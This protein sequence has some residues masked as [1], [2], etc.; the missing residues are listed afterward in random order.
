M[1][2]ILGVL[3]L[4][5]VIGIGAPKVHAITLDDL[6]KEISSLKSQIV[7]LKTQLSA[8]ALNAT[9]VGT[10]TQPKTT[11]TPASCE[12]KNAA[13][14]T[15]TD[16]LAGQTCLDWAQ[17]FAGSGITLNKVR[18]A[19]LK[20]PSLAEI[21]KCGYV[22][23]PAL[24]NSSS[25]LAGYSSLTEKP[26]RGS[27]HLP[28]NIAVSSFMVETQ[29]CVP[30]IVEKSGI[31]DVS[32]PGTEILKSDIQKLDVPVSNFLSL[33]KNLYRGL[34]K[35]LEV[36]KLQD[37]LKANG[38]LNKSTGSSG[39]YGPKTETAVRSL[40]R[41][42]GVSAVGIVGPQTRTLLGGGASTDS[43]VKSNV[44]G[45]ISMWYG[46]VNQH[47]DPNGQWMTDPDGSA[48]AGNYSQWGNDGWGDRKVEYCQRFWPGTTSV[49]EAGT[50]TITT[51]H[52][53]GN[54]GDYT[55]TKPVFS[56]V[57]SQIVTPTPSVITDRSTGGSGSIFPPG[58]TSG[59]GYSSTTGLPC[60]GSSLGGGTGTT[61]PSLCNSLTPSIRVISP[62]GG[63]TYTA[64][65]QVTVKWNDCNIPQDALVTIDLTYLTDY[66]FVSNNILLSPF[67]T[68]NDGVEIVTLPSQPFNGQQ[69]GLHYKISVFLVNSDTGDRSDNLFTINGPSTDVACTP[70]TAPYIKVISPNGGETFTAGQQITVK[71]TSCNALP[72]TQ[73]DIQLYY[74]NPDVPGLNGY[75]GLNNMTLNDGEETVLV[76][77]PATFGW[78][79]G[80]HFKVRVRPIYTSP[81]SEDMSDNLFTINN[82][83]CS[84]QITKLT[85][86]NQT[87]F[88]TT[89]LEIYK[90]KLTNLSTS[91][92]CFVD[93]NAF[94]ITFFTS[95]QNSSI[96]N[97]RLIDSESNQQY[98][99]TIGV[100]PSSGILTIPNMNG[101]L[102]PGATK[103]FSFKT[104]VSGLPNF[105][106]QYV[107]TVMNS[108]IGHDSV[109]GTTINPAV[110]AEVQTM[111]TQ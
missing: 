22:D 37:Y 60:S 45:Q 78:L 25:N 63:E 111:T 59:L 11:I 10:S 106:G 48:G 94:N 79:T 2:K 29:V 55:S 91:H 47:R 108:L 66:G 56:C 86:A 40:Q 39:D 89:N 42:L 13:D 85:Q 95:G 72:T 26:I 93:S 7:D 105:P 16:G 15:Q 64:G 104:D 100:L 69:F 101:W 27:L 33:S 54:V 76:P 12:W 70:T 51:W 74:L 97:F 24:L 14:L 83:P 84:I 49:E 28:P 5:A 67:T 61:P 68:I 44:L 3:L 43:T 52:N 18:T 53:A 20:D 96:S 8:A 32:K 6:A 80:T 110:P 65:Q 46:K 87:L 77:D 17:S 31:V 99:W 107:A 73:L 58:C 36:M 4:L 34:S 62:N 38:Y 109:T 57:G 103:I 88:N 21:G 71:W 9:K 35:D 98:G 102:T 50:A 82:S 30:L 1:K 19:G 92:P 23:V 81:I 75:F 41:A 90:F